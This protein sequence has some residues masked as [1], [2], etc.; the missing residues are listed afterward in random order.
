[1]AGVGQTVVDKVEFMGGAENGT[2][3]VE[4]VSFGYGMGE[5]F[6][7]GMAVG[8][9]E[10]YVKLIGENFFAIAR[11]DEGEKGEQ[12]KLKNILFGEM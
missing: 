7:V 4:S 8:W 12:S 11:Y 1:M 3:T 2:K 10:L 9:V 5:D 6:G